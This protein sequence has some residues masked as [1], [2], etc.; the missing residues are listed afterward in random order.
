MRDDIRTYGDFHGLSQEDFEA[1]R[2]EIP[3]PQVE[4][5]DGVLKVDHEGKFIW[6]DDFLD[7]MVELL[8]DKGWGGVDFIDHL[9][10]KL[11]RYDIRG[12]KMTKKTIDFDQALGSPFAQ[13]ID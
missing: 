1:I 3:Y 10:K 9:D 5:K 6:I 7:R 11:T 12:G 8:G 4:F 13:Q 2:D